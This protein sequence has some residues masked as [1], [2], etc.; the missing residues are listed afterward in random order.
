MPSSEDVLALTRL[1]ALARV[2]RDLDF[3][4]SILTH[5]QKIMSVSGTFLSG[6]TVGAAS[7]VSGRLLRGAPQSGEAVARRALQQGGIALYLRS[8]YGFLARVFG[9]HRALQ[10]LFD[11]LVGTWAVNGLFLVSGAL[12]KG[13][14]VSLRPLSGMVRSGLMVWGPANAFGMLALSMPN[15]IRFNLFV[16]FLWGIYLSSL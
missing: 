3:S 12:L 11:Q 4:F 10:L 14:S 9:K 13:E 6:A 16:S 2:G 7:E 1:V 15:R 8:Y 5:V